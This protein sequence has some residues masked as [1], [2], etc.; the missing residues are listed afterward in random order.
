MIGS[1]QADAD[2]PHQSADRAGIDTQVEPMA[3]VRAGDVQLDRR[4][5]RLDAE[6]LGHRHELVLVLAGDVGDHRRAHRAEIRQVMLDEMR[7]AVV[8]QPDRVEE[9]RGG[10]DRPWGRVARS[11]AERHRLGD[12]PAQPLEPDER[13]HLADVA[14]RPRRHQHRVRQRQPPQCPHSGQPRIGSD[15]TDRPPAAGSFSQAAPPEGKPATPTAPV[16]ETADRC[17][18]FTH[19]REAGESPQPS[20]EIHENRR[21][22]G[23]PGE[24][25]R[26]NLAPAV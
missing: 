15:S 17:I 4:Q 13:R 9:A 20:C 5:A 21:D 7:D 10:L 6:H 25:R 23:P 16:G 3:D 11:R 12:H 19:H 26:H 18:L 14:E 1:G 8:I 24:I 22:S 2:P